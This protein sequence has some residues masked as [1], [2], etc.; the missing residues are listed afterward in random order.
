MSSSCQQPYSSMDIIPTCWTYQNRTE[1]HATECC[2]KAWKVVIFL[3]EDSKDWPCILF[4]LERPCRYRLSPHRL[5]KCNCENH[6][7][8]GNSVSV[9]CHCLLIRRRSLPITPS[10]IRM[11]SVLQRGLWRLRRRAFSKPKSAAYFSL[12]A[13]IGSVPTNAQTKRPSMK[14]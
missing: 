3:A 11:S 4:P 8:H 10:V 5:L 2:R 9:S 13:K 14:L 12:R 7:L 1:V 6:P